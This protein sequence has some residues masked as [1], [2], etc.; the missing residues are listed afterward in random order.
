MTCWC[1]GPALDKATNRRYT[2]RMRRI[3][4]ALLAAV[5]FASPALA[6]DA[7]NSIF[8]GL[9]HVELS[10]KDRDELD[11]ISAYFNFIAEEHRARE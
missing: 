6:A 5:L 7:G 8:P 10:S 2:P 9:R 11:A 1:G 3:A 4:L